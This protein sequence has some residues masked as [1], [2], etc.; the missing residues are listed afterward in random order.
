MKDYG[1]N[2]RKAWQ[3]GECDKSPYTKHKWKHA[4]NLGRCYNL[5]TCEYCGAIVRID[6]S[7]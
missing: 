3:E 2:N 6:S 1:T 4:K 7:D 5:E